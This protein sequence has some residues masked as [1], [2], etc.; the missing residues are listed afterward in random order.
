MDRCE[1]HVKREKAGRDRQLK[2]KIPVL[3]RFH[4]FPV[5]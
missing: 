3:S 5:V 4:A 2:V 1:L